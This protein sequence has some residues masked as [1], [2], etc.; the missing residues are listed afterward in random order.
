MEPTT[1]R[2][3]QLAG[4]EGAFRVPV[5][6]GKYTLHAIDVAT[7]VVLFR[8]DEIEVAAG[9][10]RHQDLAIDVVE[11]QVRCEAAGRKQLGAERVEVRKSDQRQR[12]TTLFGGGRYGSPGAEIDQV[13][14]SARLFLPPGTCRLRAGV[15]AVPMQGM[16][17]W[18]TEPAAEETIEATPGKVNEVTLELPDPADPTGR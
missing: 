10:I 9:A 13:T 1:A 7:G 8:T 11:V 14:R 16:F 6:A 18:G 4:S 17:G 2:S 3:W 5:V 15:G 12:E